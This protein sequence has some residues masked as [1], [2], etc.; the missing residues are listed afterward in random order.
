MIY[1]VIKAINPPKI[2]TFSGGTYSRGGDY[3]PAWAKSSGG[4]N[5][6]DAIK[7]CK[8]LGLVPG[9]YVQFKATGFMAEITS[10][11]WTGVKTVNGEL[12]VLRVKQS[13]ETYEVAA[14]EV[15]LVEFDDLSGFGC[16]DFKFY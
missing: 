1:Q 12:C 4:S 14:S 8:E 3:M 10:F 2:K 6:E 11:I 15:E 7:K 16:H 9:K 5:I 13:R